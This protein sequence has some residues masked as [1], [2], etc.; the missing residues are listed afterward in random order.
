MKVYT[1]CFTPGGE[2]TLGKILDGLAGYA[3]VD[4]GSIMAHALGSY[5][6]QK[7]ADQRIL[8]WTGR[9][10]G[11][12]AEAIQD[13]DAFVFVGAAGIA[14][15]AIAPYV[16]DKT[17]DPALVVVDEKGEFVIPLLSGHIGGAN[18]LAVSIAAHLGAQPVLTT[19]TDVRGLF[20]VDV[21]AAK[22]G[23]QIRD[24]KMAKEISAALLRGEKIGFYSE[25]P[26]EGELPAG[27]VRVP[28]ELTQRSAMPEI[29]T[30]QAEADDE[31]LRTGTNLERLPL[32]I[33]ISPE[34]KPVFSGQLQLV[35]QCLTVGIG[36]KKGTSRETIT[37]AVKA[38]FEQ[39]GLS[40]LAISEV[41]SID[42]KQNEAGLLAAVAEYGVPFTTFSAEELKAAAGDFTES[43]FVK[44]VTGVG[45]VCERAA[46]LASG[47][48]LIRK[49]TASD[50][51]TVAVAKRNVRISF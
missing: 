18:A 38:V 14:I 21:F 37:Q 10:A 13:A 1:I 41:A 5:R 48:V 29:N 34:W 11:W 40:L 23:L 46:V 31:S 43:S 6:K 39:T 26:V 12:M 47:G 28:G 20:A 35:P 9:L 44:D 7:Q 42:L 36:C 15:R 17:K 24:M 32:G 51:V 19:A 3:G 22:N 8:T 4:A 27:L 30:G 16:T 33:V 50:G 25:L 45:N 49:K 2:K